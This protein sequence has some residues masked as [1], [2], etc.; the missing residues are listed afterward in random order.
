M[1]SCGVCWARTCSFMSLLA[2]LLLGLPAHS[3]AATPE[4]PV[5]VAERPLSLP[6]TFNV[7]AWSPDGRQIAVTESD[8]GDLKVC[9]RLWLM[10]ADRGGAGPKRLLCRVPQRGFTGVV[11]P[12]GPYLYVV[13][14]RLYAEK[15]GGSLYRVRLADGRVEEVLRWPRTIVVWAQ[16]V[17]RDGRYLALQTDQAIEILDLAAPHPNRK[18]VGR[19]GGG[20]I[21]VSWSPDGKRLAVVTGGTVCVVSR[22]DGSRRA[23]GGGTQPRWSPDGRWIFF[24]RVTAQG[25]TPSGLTINEEVHAWAMR[26]DGSGRH[27][28][29]ADDRPAERL[30]V[31]PTGDRVLYSR[32][33]YREGTCPQRWFV[34]TLGPGRN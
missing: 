34:A 33:E 16:E 21:G 20:G 25:R 14:N 18:T 2:W 22:A 9:D 29:L 32:T 27:P 4:W 17:S 7:A 8:G 1:D 31:A 6:D 5:V 19:L 28:L 26:P 30:A 11:W 10:D 24:C 23:I 13:R 12:S 15:I 3:A